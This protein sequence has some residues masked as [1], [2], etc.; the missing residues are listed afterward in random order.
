MNRVPSVRTGADGPECRGPR[1]E[2][3]SRCGR[4]SEP[5]M[6]L[7]PQIRRDSQPGHAN[8]NR[9]PRDVR[10]PSGERLRSQP[11]GTPSA[12]LRRSR[13]PSRNRRLASTGARRIENVSAPEQRE[14]DRPCHGPEQAAF[15]ALEREDGHVGG[16]DDA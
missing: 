13:A 3:S 6:P 8:A 1:I 5:M 10:W 16:D 12:D 7:K 4:N 15:D 9:E 11:S 2:P 14:G